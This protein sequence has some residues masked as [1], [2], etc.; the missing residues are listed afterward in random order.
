[1]G[2]LEP[3]VKVSVL[4]S[5]HARLCNPVL[6]RRVQT[7]A[8]FEYYSDRVCVPRQIDEILE[9]VD[10]RLNVLFALEVVVQLESHECSSCLILWAERCCEFL[11]E[12]VP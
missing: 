7:A 10:V 3:A 5:V 4:R 6:S 9:L 2:S 12:F 1:L 11:S 8:E